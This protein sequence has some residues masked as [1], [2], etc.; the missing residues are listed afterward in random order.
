MTERFSQMVVLV[1]VWKEILLFSFVLLSCSFVLTYLFWFICLD[2]CFY[3]VFRHLTFF[4]LP[5]NSLFLI[6]ILSLY[7]C[8]FKF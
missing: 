3:C 4:I 5:D 2:F 1:V 7:F 8:F 6:D